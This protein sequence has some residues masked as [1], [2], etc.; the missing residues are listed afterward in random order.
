MDQRLA[1]FGYFK[2]R[3]IL[4]GNFRQAAA[5]QQKTVASFDSCDQLRINPQPD[6]TCIESVVMIK[7]ALTPEGTCHRQFKPFGKTCYLING[8][9][10]PAATA[11]YHQR[12]V[13][14]LQTFD[15]LTDIVCPRM[16]FRRKCRGER[17][18]FSQTC[19]R[20]F[21]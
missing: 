2:Q 3:K 13:C 11:Q 8:S 1:R 18:C 5:N 20:V 16:S 12:I 19:Q 15:H 17:F 9:L 21:R 6:I 4:R 14:R 10:T 7:Q